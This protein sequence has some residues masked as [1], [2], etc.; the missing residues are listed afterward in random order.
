MSATH[1]SGPLFVGG[2]QVGLGGLLPTTG[3][4]W[5]LSPSTSAQNPG[6]DG[7]DGLSLNTPK[8]TLKACYD[9]MA[10]GDTLYIMPYKSSD[11]WALIPTATASGVTTG[12]NWALNNCRVIGLGAYGNLEGRASIRLGASDT[13]TTTLFTV[14]GYGNQFNNIYWAMESAVL[15]QR[16]LTVTGYRNVFYDCS[17]AGM[18]VQAAANDVNSRC[19]LI[20][21]GGT[22][23]VGANKFVRCH[24]GANTIQR[25]NV[26]VAEIE[27]KGMAARN[28]F[29][30]CYVWTNALTG[31]TN[32]NLFLI[33]AASSIQ[34]ILTLKN[35]LMINCSNYNGAVGNNLMAKAINVSATSGGVVAL[36]GTQV[37]GVVAGAL[38]V[39]NNGNVL[40]D[41]VGGAATGGRMIVATG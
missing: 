26:A 36:P 21:G 38:Q 33:C 23:Q 28:E 17:I 16:C 11:G 12:F 6:A 40:V 35:C 32:A 34:D 37:A 7:N 5:F 19:L 31:G 39:A 4:N 24:I 22:G 29:E 41:G 3:R 1:M 25:A 30:D 2:V 8:G 13:T 27:V 14:S 20:D 15:T 18:L 9:L 10:D